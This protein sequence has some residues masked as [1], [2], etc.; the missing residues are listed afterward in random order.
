MPSAAIEAPFA[1]PCHAPPFAAPLAA[2]GKRLDPFL[3]IH[4]I[5]TVNNTT[6]DTGV[7]PQAVEAR[8]ND[9]SYANCSQFEGSL[10]VAEGEAAAAVARV[11]ERLALAYRELG[12]NL[13]ALIMDPVQLA[14]VRFSVRRFVLRILYLLCSVD[15][16]TTCLRAS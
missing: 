4:C 9:A 8:A 15:C 13:F 16:C 12:Y 10:V 5:H 2:T 11:E 1:S 14:R 7:A 3:Y 6:Y